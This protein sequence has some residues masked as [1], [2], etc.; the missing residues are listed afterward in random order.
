MAQD[1]SLALVETDQGEPA[2]ALATAVA[3][4]R[5]LADAGALDQSTREAVDAL[6]DAAEDARQRLAAQDAR[7][8]QL[9]NLS[10]TDELTGLLNR[11]GFL[12]ELRRALARA[13][14]NGE[15]GVVLLCDLDRFKA[16]NDTYGH[17]AG[18]AALVVV[19]QLLANGVRAH[20]AVGR[21]GGDEFGVLLA[22]VRP[23]AIGPRLGDIRNR[24]SAIMLDFDETRVP[25]SASVGHAAYGPNTDSE[26]LLQMADK[27]LYRAKSR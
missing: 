9:L 6:V 26:I 14:R 25:L 13:E 4:L 19:G 23:C 27:A 22:D 5:A 20:D 7:I 18:D 12:T 1:A 24:L 15:T 21:L 10:V 2:P 16:I 17:A 11:R 3:Y 8:R